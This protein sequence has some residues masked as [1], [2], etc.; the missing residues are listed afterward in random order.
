MTILQNFLTGFYAAILLLASCLLLSCGD[1]GNDDLEPIIDC[2]PL[3]ANFGPAQLELVPRDLSY[4]LDCNVT[5][6]FTSQV[7]ISED[8]TNRIIS[9]N[10]IPNHMIADFTMLSMDTNS[11]FGVSEINETYT[12]PTN[13]E[14][15]DNITT[16]WSTETGPHYSFGVLNNGVL[17]EPEAFEPFP[18]TDRFSL[19]ANLEWNLD[20]YIL[21]FGIDCNNGHVQ[22]GGE[23][24]Y[25]GAPTLYLESLNLTGNEMTM[26]GYAGD[27]FPIYYK[28]GFSAANDANSAVET[29]TSS[30]RLKSGYRPGDGVE[31]PCGEYNGVYTNDWEY[32][33]GLGNLDECNG[34]SGVTPE[35]PDGTYYYVIMDEF[36]FIPRCFKGTPSEDF[37]LQ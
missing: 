19:D 13:P 22:P 4:R 18:H 36:P 12:I 27:G 26:I 6:P 35:F 30:Y 7:S 10:N 23:Y 28:Y 37:N 5:L 1:D 15:A 11:V 21:S 20:V 8:G 25:H 2:P 32:V 31:A 24:H 33:E 29:L 16:L 14:I 34:R 9:S 3:V 17:I